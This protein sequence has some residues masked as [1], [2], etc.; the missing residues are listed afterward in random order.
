[1]MSAN[2]DRTFIAEILARHNMSRA[3]T[4]PVAGTNATYPTF[5]C[6]DVV[7]KLF[8]YF[9]AWRKSYK[10]ERTAHILIATDPKIAAPRLLAEGSLFADVAAPWPYLITERMSGVS[11]RRA[12]LPDRDRISIA[13]SLGRQ[14]RRVH[15]LRSPDLTAISGWQAPEIA[16][17]ARSSSLPDNLIGQIDDFLSR[18]GPFDPVFVHGDLVDNHIFVINGCLAGII[19][20]GDAMTADRH[21]ELAKLFFGAFACDKHLLRVFLDASEWPVAEDFAI[22]TLGLA[23]HRQALGTV[24]HH[25]FDVFHTLP[26]RIRHRGIATLDDLATELF[27]I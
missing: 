26:A 16:A 12:N 3:G 14:I 22:K 15:R 5:V 7:V 17:S 2:G 20:W 23:L 11:W 8:G 24:Q 6:G 4:E 18:L 19:D 27:A 9:R 10:A 1:M 13:I 25:S 21:Y